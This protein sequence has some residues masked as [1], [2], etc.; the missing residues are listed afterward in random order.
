MDVRYWRRIA[1]RSYAPSGQIPARI[2]SNGL[3]PLD[4]MSG[5]RFD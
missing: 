5:G 3:G 1:V 2:S 4:F